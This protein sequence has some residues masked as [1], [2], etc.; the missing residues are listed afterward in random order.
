M[1]ELVREVMIDATPAPT[2]PMPNTVCSN[3]NTVSDSPSTSRT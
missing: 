2:S 3:A 1:G